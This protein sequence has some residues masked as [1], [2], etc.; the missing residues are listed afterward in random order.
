MIATE[1]TIKIVTA[2]TKIEALLGQLQDGIADVVEGLTTGMT[3]AEIM[4]LMDN[5]V[6]GRVK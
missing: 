6:N 1:Q 3:D 4:D 5:V 2:L